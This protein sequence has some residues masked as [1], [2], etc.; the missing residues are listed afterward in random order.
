MKRFCKQGLAALLALLVA[1]GGLTACGQRNPPGRGEAS[2]SASQEE[3][4]PPQEEPSSVP[5]SSSL[6]QEEPEESSSE[7]AVHVLESDYGA[8][9]GLDTTRY[10]W[11]P[12][13]PVDE[14]NR[15][16]GALAYNE[17]FGQYNAVFL[18]EDSQDIYLT[19]DMGYENGYT[20]AILD[21]LKE[22]GA[23]GVF[24]LTDHYAQTAPDLVQRMIDEGHV[25]GNHSWGH[26]ENIN[27]LPLE[28]VEECIT[29]LHTYIDEEFGYDMRL[30]RCPAGVFTQQQ[31]ALAQQLGYRTVF[32]SF[33]YRDWIVDDQPDP[34]EALDTMLS[35]AHPGA[36]YLIHA[37]SQ[38][39]SQIL[40]QVIDGMREKGFTIG[41]PNDLIR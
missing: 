29:K 32:W 23:K 33:A 35:K 5:E 37:V 26:P 39:N 2:G 30:W 10:D 16:Q 21:T 31:L 11:G 9:A 4:A 7:A 15:S 38:T 41:D 20:P 34:A 22:K 36:I 27:E 40:G 19:F 17:K 25:L 8:L 13:G 24:F 14:L 12:G 6:P 3:S 18:E 1:A 28:E